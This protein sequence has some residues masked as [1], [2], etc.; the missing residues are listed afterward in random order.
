MGPGGKEQDRGSVGMSTFVADCT[1]VTVQS[2]HCTV[3]F[4]CYCAVAMTY[5]AVAGCHNNI[6]SHVDAP[7]EMVSA[8]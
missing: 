4:S 3:I 7:S 1:V 2:S 6:A 5:S 8:L